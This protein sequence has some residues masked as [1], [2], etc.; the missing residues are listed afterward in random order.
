MTSRYPLKPIRKK[1]AV[2]YDLED[3]SLSRVVTVM[4]LPPAPAGWEERH[5]RPWARLLH[6]NIPTVYEIARQRGCTYVISEQWRGECLQDYLDDERDLG[7]RGVRHVTQQLL[8]A[9]RHAHQSGTV[10]GLLAPEQMM[11]CGD[12]LLKLHHHSMDPLESWNGRGEPFP[13]GDIAAYQSPEQL[14]GHAASPASDIWAVGVLLYRLMGGALPFASE[15]EILD[16]E[17]AP[18]VPFVGFPRHAP[19]VVGRCLRKEPGER[20]PSVDEL[21]LSLYPEGPVGLPELRRARDLH[22][23]ALRL[24]EL[25]EWAAAAVCWREVDRFCP[26]EA[27]ILNN[28]GS[29]LVQLEQFQEA[30]EAFTVASELAPEQPL[31]AAHLDWTLARAGGGPDDGKRPCFF[32]QPDEAFLAPGGPDW[33]LCV[34]DNDEELAR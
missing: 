32:D 24:T 17:P 30:A 15:D 27:G 13:T 31:F 23:E 11:L 3:D 9:L 10:H 2:I 6:P 5:V 16:L 20:F 28:L 12:G 4:G 21:M 1:R 18:L 8:Q 29:A 25:Q 22:R 19:E 34:G 14:E 33:P 7:P 26:G